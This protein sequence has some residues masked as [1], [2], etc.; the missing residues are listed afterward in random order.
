MRGG[1]QKKS[2]VPETVRRWYRKIGAKGGQAG[3]GTDIRRE[4]MRAN[5]RKRWAREK[6]RKAKEKAEL[7]RI[8]VPAPTPVP[9]S[10]PQVGF[11]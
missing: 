4:L 3:K 6:A 8:M 9:A 7:S 1:R 2:G 10:V 5:A 11:K